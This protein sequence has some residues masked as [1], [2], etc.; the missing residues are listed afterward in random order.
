MDYFS[1]SVDE[2]LVEMADPNPEREMRAHVWMT[3]NDGSVL[4]WAG[5]ARCDTQANENH[6]AEAC[7]VYFQQGVQDEMHYYRPVLL[8]RE[9]LIRT[10]S[11]RVVR[12]H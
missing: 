5:Q 2:L 11:I 4:D 7:L 3:F 8:G 1:T 6:S 10:G 9:Y 12:S